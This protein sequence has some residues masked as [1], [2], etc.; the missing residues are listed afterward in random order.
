MSYFDFINQASP[1]KQRRLPEKT[2]TS[3]VLSVSI[4]DELYES[5]TLNDTPGEP[6]LSSLHSNNKNRQPTTDSSPQSVISSSALTSQ[7]S[8]SDTPSRQHPATSAGS[9][10]GVSTSVFGFINQAI[11]QDDI[12]AVDDL[13]FATRQPAGPSRKPTTPPR[14]PHH[15][16]IDQQRTPTPRQMEIDAISS[17]QLVSSPNRKTVEMQR[18]FEESNWK[19]IKAG[20]QHQQQLIQQLYEQRKATISELQNNQTLLQSK[21]EDEQ[22]AKDNEDYDTLDK[23]IKQRQLVKA[24]IDRLKYDVL[25][26]TTQQLH[27]AWMKMSSLTRTEGECA[28]KVAQTYQETKNERQQQFTQYNVDMKRKH[29]GLLEKIKADRSGIESAK[30]EVAFDLDFWKQSK[31]ELDEKMAEAVQEKT[32]EKNDLMAKVVSVD[33]SN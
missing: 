17:S 7:D 27:T 32:H 19:R 3:S 1:Y 4:A 30:S 15:Y 22:R 31:T 18:L 10:A 25:E 28:S 9:G 5:Q 6:Q 29:D 8:F 13:V 2:T 23:L 24:N 26:A 33:V 12:Q 11:K 14:H 16:E 21:S 20:K